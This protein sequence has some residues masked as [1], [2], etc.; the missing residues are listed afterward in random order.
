LILYVSGATSIGKDSKG[1]VVLRGPG[2]VAKHAEI[3]NEKGEVTLIPLNGSIL[4][5]GK[6]IAQ[7]VVLCHGDR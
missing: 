4:H 7:S 5:N 1:T 3:K 6:E 2:I